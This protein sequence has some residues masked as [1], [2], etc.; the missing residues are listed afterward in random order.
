MRKRLRARWLG[1]RS[2]GLAPGPG[3]REGV[4]DV[5]A[6][7]S[8]GVV[9]IAGVG[10][11]PLGVIAVV[12]V[13]QMDGIDGT[14]CDGG[15]CIRE[16]E[17]QLVAG[18]D[19]AGGNG[20]LGEKAADATIRSNLAHITHVSVTVGQIGTIIIEKEMDGIRLVHQIRSFRPLF[21]LPLCGVLI[22]SCCYCLG[23][24]Y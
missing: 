6:A 12:V 3:L 4:E 21:Y 8:G 17:G 10:G 7:G 14:V 16:P 1:A 13:G 2:G 9:G 15:G 11:D 23:F 24:Y 20:E 5:V 19:A 18:L 22:Y